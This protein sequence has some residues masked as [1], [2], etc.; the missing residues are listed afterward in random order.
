MFKRTMF[1][2][3]HEAFRSTVRDFLVAE[4]VPN[5]GKWLE[6]GAP[7]EL[8]RKLGALGVMGFGIPEEYGGP[9]DVSYKY[10]AIISEE[11]ARVAVDLSHYMV[12]TGIV[13]PYLLNLANEEQRWRW[14]PAIA[15]GDIVLAIAMTEPGTGSDLAGISTTAWLSDDGSQ[16]VLNGAKTFITG[17][18]NAELTIVVAR[19]SPPGEDRR[20][21]LSLLVVENASAGFEVGRKL[22][23]I[24]QHATDTSELS[25]TDVV[26]PAENLLGEEGRGFGTSARTCRGSASPSASTQPPPQLRRSSS[27]RRTCGSARSSDARSRT[28]RT[29]SSSLPSAPRRWL[30]P[31]HWRIVDS[32]WTRQKSSAS[33]MLRR[34]SCSVPRSPAG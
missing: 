24:G 19:T 11:T 7:R 14:L 32:S 18:R 26:V 9:G 10:Q 13:L 15:S 2:A 28:S 20:S 5:Y 1:D 33:P 25:F 16:Y 8:F 4:V 3:G 6:E 17:A 30:P 31:R 27:P 34:S 21:G 29:L 22:H 23:K 12:S